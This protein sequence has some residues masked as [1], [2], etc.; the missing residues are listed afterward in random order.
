MNWTYALFI[1][2]QRRLE[3]E[4]KEIEEEQK[5]L[6]RRKQ[7]LLRKHSAP[8]LKR[9]FPV[10]TSGRSDYDDETE[11]DYDDETTPSKNADEFGS[12]DAS[13]EDSYYQNIR[14]SEAGL[15]SFFIKLPSLKS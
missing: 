13:E 9:T 15:H 3:Q 2:E 7:L 4:E 5:Q 12:D 8:N 14:S 10:F 11:S 1:V 6:I